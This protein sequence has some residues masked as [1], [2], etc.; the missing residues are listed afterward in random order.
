MRVFSQQGINNKEFP[1]RGFF[2]Q[3]SHSF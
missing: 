3:A 1:W 2:S